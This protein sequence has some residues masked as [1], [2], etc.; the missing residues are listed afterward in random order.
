MAKKEDG[1][2]TPETVQVEV[3][4][5]I[6]HDGNVFSRGIHDL[7]KGLADVFLKLKD[8]VSKKPIAQIPQE[9]ERAKG[10]VEKDSAAK[11]KK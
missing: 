4:H 1:P 7:E 2:G 3:L 10:T 9:K 5:P 8:P 6:N 11:E